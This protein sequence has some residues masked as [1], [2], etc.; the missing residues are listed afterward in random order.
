MKPV[1]FQESDYIY[2]KGTLIDEIFFL[3]RGMVGY[4]LTE[5]DD[6]VFVNI[7]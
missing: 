7:H 1:K 6:L 5:F 3:T 4:V 2:T